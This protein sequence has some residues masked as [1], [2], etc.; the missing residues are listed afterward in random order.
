MSQSCSRR[1]LSRRKRVCFAGIVIGLLIVV[2]ET[3]SGVALHLSDV[4]FSFRKLHRAQDGIAKVGVAEGERSVVIHPYLGWVS[5]PQMDS[6]IEYDG[7]VFPVNDMG[8]ADDSPTIQERS[9]DKLIVGILGGSVAWQMSV[10]GEQAFVQALVKSPRFRDKQVEI[11][12]LAQSGYKQ[13]QQLLT[14]SY[15]LALGAEFDLIINIDGYN[16]VALHVAEN[17]ESGVFYAFPRGW[18]LWTLDLGDPRA[19]SVAYL[20]MQTKHTRQEW[21]RRFSKLPFRYSYT[22]NLVWKWRD[23]ALQR[24][25]TQLGWDLL[26]RKSTEGR[27]YQVTGPANPYENDEDL[28]QDMALLWKR[29]SLQLHQICRANGIE[30]I[31][32]LQPNQYVPGSKPISDEERRDVI[33][34]RQEYGLAAGK[35]YPYLIREGAGL[36]RKGVRFYDMTMLFSQTT[37]RIY[38]DPFCHYNKLGNEMLARAIVGEMDVARK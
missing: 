18:G 37:E 29:C 28:Y 6:G 20:V 38:S 32:V 7:R 27:G 31:H 24:E 23:S 36:I 10:A 35:G 4:N 21:S 12:R 33:F 30:Y 16:E 5:N 1:R 8:F 17:G 14:L 26:Q 15:V 34:P 19:G 9:K 25:L 3:A 22:L 2:A 13:P 11:V